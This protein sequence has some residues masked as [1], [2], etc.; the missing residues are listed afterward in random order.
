MAGHGTQRDE[1]AAN[2]KAEASEDFCPVCR[3]EE[4]G[5][6]GERIEWEGRSYWFC[7]EACRDEFEAAP[8]RYTS[9]T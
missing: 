5:G 1:S 2:G 8:E 6:T 3:M 9:G 7:N 4:E